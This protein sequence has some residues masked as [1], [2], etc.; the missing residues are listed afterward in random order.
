VSGDNYIVVTW[1]DLKQIYGPG[2]WEDCLK[3]MRQSARGQG[4][5]VSSKEGTLC[6]GPN[7]DNERVA[8]IIED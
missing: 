5:R 7:F 1:P 2:T 8:A 3:W 4:M 6:K